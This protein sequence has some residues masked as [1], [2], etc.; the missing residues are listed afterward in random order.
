MDK[1][2]DK[3][4]IILEISVIAIVL[5]FWGG[6]WGSPFIGPSNFIDEGQFGAWI[7]HINH[8]EHLFKDIFIVYGPLS[9]YALLWLAKLF[10]FSI[11]LIR[12]YLTLGALPGFVVL[13]LISYKFSFSKSLRYMLYLVFLLLPILSMRQGMFMLGLYLF[14]SAYEKGVLYRFIAGVVII[15]SLLVSQEYGIFLIALFII[16]ASFEYLKKVGNYKYILSIACGIVIS[17]SIFATIAIGNGWFVEYI[18]DTVDVITSFSG[19]NVPNGMNFP[20]LFES[21]ANITT[22]FQAIKIF[23]DTTRI[24]YYSLVVYVISIQYLIISAFSKKS[25]KEHLYLFFI[26]L[27]GLLIMP[28][29]ITRPG[30]ANFFGLLWPVIIILFYFINLLIKEVAGKKKNIVTLLLLTL[31]CLFIAR[32]ISLYRPNL[33]QRVRDISLIPKVIGSNNSIARVG[34]MDLKREQTKQVLGMKRIV[35]KYSKEGEFIFFFNDEPMYYF[36]FNRRNPTRFDL[37]FAANTLS[38]RYELLNSIR[39]NKTKLIIIDQNVWAVDG[40]NNARRLPELY[41]YII[42]NYERVKTEDKSIIVFIKK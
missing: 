20:K 12:E 4:E 15:I 14:L 36:L 38:K 19:Q 21:P 41:S 3:K 7:N 32:V 1:I 23:F 33:A 31:C 25:S 11:F 13:Y 18:R 28:S 42:E 2:L 8:G 17:F 5:I 26:T 10:G 40:I 22:P 37:P 16:R 9:V 24:Y 39:T 29:L 35:D 27:S 30:I 34:T 6:G